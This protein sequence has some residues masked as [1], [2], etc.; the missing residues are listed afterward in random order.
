[1]YDQPRRRTPTLVRQVWIWEGGCSVRCDTLLCVYARRAAHEWSTNRTVTGWQASN[2][3]DASIP[4]VLDCIPPIVGFLMSMKFK[5]C[6]LMRCER[7]QWQTVARTEH[8]GNVDGMLPCNWISYNRYGRNGVHLFDIK[9][10]LSTLN[11]GRPPVFG[12]HRKQS[13]VS[14][15]RPMQSLCPNTSRKRSPRAG[16]ACSG[17]ARNNW[18]GTKWVHKPAFTAVHAAL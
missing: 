4:F 16:R 3:R 11:D 18:M 7:V 6:A 13:I 1:M 15:Q 5:L 10:E 14:F 12:N 8:H 17:L 2:E 9:R